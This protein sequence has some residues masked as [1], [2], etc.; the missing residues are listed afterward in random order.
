MQQYHWPGNVRELENALQRA[1][2]LRHFPDRLDD[3][4]F[5]EIG[6]GAPAAPAPSP[7]PSTATPA[8]MPV[9]AWSPEGLFAIPPGGIIL[10]EVEAKLIRTAM[11]QTSNN[12]TR[13]AELL[14]ISRQTLI[15][16]LQKYG[17][18]KST[19]NQAETGNTDRDKAGDD[20]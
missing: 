12:Q 6:T 15:Y 8:P 10:D 17:I 7:S 4:D 19:D 20:T 3:I 18:S 16:R 9:G 1:I 14:G 13:A 5:P 2:A 11:R